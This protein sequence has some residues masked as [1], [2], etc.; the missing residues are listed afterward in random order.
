MKRFILLAFIVI[1]SFTTA[2]GS[3]PPATSEKAKMEATTS[4]QAVSVENQMSSDGRGNYG[5][6]SEAKPAEP[7]T[8]QMDQMIIYNGQMSIEVDELQ[9]ATDLLL[10]KVK[11]TQ[12]YL[13]N[14][15]INEND[16]NLY[17]HYEFRIPVNGFHSLIDQIKKMQI[18]KITYQAINGN[19]VTEEYLDLDSR[20]KAKKVY[21]ER[22]L[23]FLKQATKTEDLLK[24]SNDLNRVQEEI[25]QIQGRLTYLS[26]HAGNS[27]LVVDMV[28]Y[29]NKTAPT[30]SAW[31]KAVS[32]FNRSVDFIVD[33]FTSLFIGL[34]SFFP[35]LILLLFVFLIFWWLGRKKWRDLYVKGTHGDKK[36]E[37]KEEDKEDDEEKTKKEQ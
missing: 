30:A 8:Y 21:E 37:E 27:T 12:G 15:N 4:D 24:I 28:Q 33:L 14:S 22:L 10:Q 35:I 34:I 13:V 36:S 2:C 11:E 26:Y 16:E 17:A 5:F 32:G 19:D 31:E 23:L 1:L 25:E 18:G 29:K 3:N 20:L 9:K 7:P 6:R